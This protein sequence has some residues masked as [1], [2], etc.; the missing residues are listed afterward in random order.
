MNLQNENWLGTS[1]LLLPV[2]EDFY[3]R[4]LRAVLIDKSGQRSERDFQVSVRRPAAQRLE[5]PVLR[6]DGETAALV[7]PGM[8]A[9]R[10]ESR[11]SSQESLFKIFNREGTLVDEFKSSLRSFEVSQFLNSGQEPVCSVF[12]L[13]LDPHRGYWLKSRAQEIS[14]PGAFPEENP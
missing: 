3:G 7:F 2:N 1:R 12:I 9:L 10:E 8:D 14:A 13:T 11:D 4:R 6:Q 5:F